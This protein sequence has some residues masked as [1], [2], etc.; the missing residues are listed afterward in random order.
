MEINGPSRFRHPKSQSTDRFL[1]VYPHS[2]LPN[3]PSHSST[4]V[5]ELNEDDIFL[6]GDFSDNS[7][8][9]NSA[10]GLPNSHY[11]KTSPSSTPFNHKSFPHS[12]NFGILAAIR[13]PS[14]PQSHFYQKPSIS[15]S[16]SS[17]SSVT[18]AASSARSIPSVPK[19]PQER[20]PVVSSSFSGRFHQSAPVN[21]PIL[22]KP[23]RKRQDFDDDYDMELEEEGEMLPPHE[24][25]ARSLA[26]SPALACSVLEGAGRTLKGR[27]L[28]QSSVRLNEVRYYC[29]MLGFGFPWWVDSFEFLLLGLDVHRFG[30]NAVNYYCRMLGFGF[31]WCLGSFDLLLFGLRCWKVDCSYIASVERTFGYGEL[32]SVLSGARQLESLCT[33]FS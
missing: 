33:V 22:A 24:I 32:C 31:H 1:G 8:G 29:R 2:P 17:S 6:S 12:E 16:A 18:S 21:V 9:S 11:Q 19:P 3:N 28:R 30:L 27:D 14:R 23:M 26:Q 7:I 4:V 5:E 10:G 20:I 15:T 25:V 13:N